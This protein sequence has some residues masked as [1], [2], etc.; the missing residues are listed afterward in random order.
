MAGDHKIVLSGY[1]DI[2]AIVSAINEGHIYKFMAKPW[3]DDELKIAVSNA[4]DKYFMQKKNILLT[5]ELA[6]KNMELKGIVD[7]K[8]ADLIM[9]SKILTFSQ[10]ILEDLPVSVIGLDP[11]G[12]IFLCNGKSFSIFNPKDG[13][14]IGEQRT[15]FFSKEINNF[16]D[17]IIAKGA[18]ALLLMQ[19]CTK[20]KAN[21]IHIKSVDGLSGIILTFD[22]IA[23]DENI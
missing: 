9:S 16:I 15:S 7:R 13:I 14:I 11:N 19:N 17:T 21:G 1:A 22:E 10:Q 18:N 6:I 4:L 5:K 3:N 12:V 20:I 23:A 2:P 8:S